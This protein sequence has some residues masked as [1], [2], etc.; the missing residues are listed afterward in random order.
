MCISL[1]SVATTFKILFSIL[2]ITAL[3]WSRWGFEEFPYDAIESGE[4]EQE[5]G[6]VCVVGQNREVK[7]G[8]LCTG[9]RAKN[10]RK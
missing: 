7:H 5:L 8:R 4:Q 1:L 10:L 9:G 6:D 2:S 3:C